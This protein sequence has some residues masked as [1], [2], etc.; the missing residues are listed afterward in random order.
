[1][2]CTGQ[3]G[4]DGDRLTPEPPTTANDSNRHKVT[5]PGCS[6][7]RFLSAAQAQALLDRVASTDVAGRVRH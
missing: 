3:D 1:M 6:T 2:C 5:T 4:D 7:K